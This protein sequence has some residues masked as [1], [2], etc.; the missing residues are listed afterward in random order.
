[1]IYNELLRKYK[2]LEV[3]DDE[4]DTGHSSDQI[5]EQAR[6]LLRNFKFSINLAIL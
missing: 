5:K 6:T 3:G 1:M 2:E 4:A